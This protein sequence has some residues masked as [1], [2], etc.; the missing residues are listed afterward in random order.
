[1]RTRSIILGVV[2]AFAGMACGG[3]DDGGAIDQP[4]ETT[5]VK[6]T[7]DNAFE[8][9]SIAVSVGDTVNWTWEGTH[10][11]VADDGSF[12]SG[13]ATAD[14]AFDHTFA[15]AGTFK[16]YC[17]IHGSAGGVGMAGTVTVA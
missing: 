9:A 7:I 8:P 3:T 16:Y 2:L 4:V 14:S 12:T 5:D 13:E 10:N 17:S 1:M 11:V 6:G 15:T